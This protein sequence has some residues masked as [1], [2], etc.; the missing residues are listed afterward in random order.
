MPGVASQ[1]QLLPLVETRGQSPRVHTSSLKCATPIR[2][3][4]SM[5]RGAADWIYILLL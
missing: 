1:A 5:Y 2:V 4:T 3:A